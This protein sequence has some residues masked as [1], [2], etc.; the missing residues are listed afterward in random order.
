MSYSDRGAVA[1]ERSDPYGLLGSI[2]TGEAVAV[3][4]PRVIV[5]TVAHPLD[6]RADLVADEFERSGTQ[7]VLLVPTRIL[8]EDLPLVNPAEGIGECGQKGAGCE[9][10]IEH[11]GRPIGCLDLVN[12]HVMALPRAAHTFGRIDDL[13]PAR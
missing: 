4:Q 3:R 2:E 10:Q 13:V 8:V 11:D 7:D 6:R 1:A 9:L 5:I 12:H